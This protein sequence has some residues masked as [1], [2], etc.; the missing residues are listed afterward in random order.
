MPF[1]DAY[2]RQAALLLRVLPHVAKEPDLALR[3]GTA[4]N[5]FIRDMP[6]LSVDIDLTYVPVQPREQSLDAIEAA[7]RRIAERIRRAIKGA[8]ITE[9]KIEGHVN[10][11]F[12]RS[13]G[14]QIKI[15]VNTVIRGCVQP[16]ETRSVTEE[17]EAAF[18]FAEANVASF[19]DLYAGKIVAALDRQHP[20][21]LFDIRDL[22]AAEGIDDTLRQ[23]FIVYL[24]SH[25]RPMHEVLR[26]TRHDI[27]P[28][29]KRGFDGMTDKPVTVE[30]LL[31]AREALIKNI[32]GDMPDAHRRFLISFERGK[33]DW[34]LLELEG[35]KDLPSVRWR[36]SNLDKLSAEKLAA[37]VAQLEGVLRA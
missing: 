21:D 17:V 7:L 12:V 2:R 31:E 8:Q 19:N 6:R 32:V 10:K 26:P 34:D 36:Q 9:T 30:E 37:L 25:D 33:P 35:V 18:G 22:L 11:L 20:R 4:I 1:S 24:L 3:G 29:F 27:T 5:L 14:V 15:E 23:A 16:P 28:E 13:E